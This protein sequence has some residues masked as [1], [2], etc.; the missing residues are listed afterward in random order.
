MTWSLSF[1]LAILAATAFAQVAP[2]HGQVAEPDRPPDLGIPSRL[3]L[4]PVERASLPNGLRLYVVEMHEVPL[5][6]FV[7]SV[8]GGGREDA[9]LAGLASFTA[10][11]M[12]EGADTLD[13]FGIAARA[14]YLGATLTTGAGWDDLSVSLKA[15]TRTMDSALSLMADVA[16]RPSFT[17]REVARQRD[18]RLAAILQQQDQPATV[19]GLAFSALVFPAGHPYHQSLGGDSASTAALDSAAVRRF[20]QWV[21]RPSGA[22]LVVA[23]DVTLA[24]IRQAVRRYFGAWRGARSSPLSRSAGFQAPATAVYLVDKPGAPQSVIRIGA[25]GVERGSTD[26]YAIEV[27]NTILGGSFS[28][29]LMTNLRETRGYTYGAGSAFEYRPLPGPFVAGAAVRSEVTDSALVEFFKEIR[30]IRDSV[31][32]PT[33]LARA[34]AYLALGLAGEFETTSQMAARVSELLTF[35]L[36]LE[37]YNFYVPRIQAVTATE[38]QRV[39]RTYIRPDKLTVVIVGDLAK[40]R[41]GVDAL[42]LGPTSVRDQHGS[43]VTQ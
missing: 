28:S 41:P 7:L 12:D 16:L 1:N 23:G 2:A 22:T 33:E 31:V 37:Y 18:L 43:E 15:P 26:Y 4:P 38:V 14:E 25:P 5:V 40:I 19:A 13:A 39:A 20:Y 35:R 36:P 11:M 8:P 9:K 24:Q 29:R 21:F 32:S 34:K 42:K 17:S 27:M 10:G 6:Q 3:H 30:R